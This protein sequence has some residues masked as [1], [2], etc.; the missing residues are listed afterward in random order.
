MKEGNPMP[1][2]KPFLTY[3][4]QL[5]KLTNEKNLVIANRKY[6]EQMLKQVGYFSLVSGYKE[7]F[8]NPTT[9]KYKD[10]T[11]FEEIVALY[12]FDEGLRE[13]FLRSLLAIE[14]KMRSLLSYYFTEHYGAEQVHYLSQAN[15]NSLPKYANEIKRLLDTLRDIAVHS[16]DNN[17]IVYQRKKHGNVPLWVLVKVLSFGNISHMYRV[18]P[19]SLQVRISKNF[20][21]VNEKELMQ[22]LRVLTKFRNV[23]AHNDRLFLYKTRDGIPDTNLHVK[24]EISKKG[25]EYVSGK[26]DL[27]CVVIALRYLLD[28]DDFKQF[29]GKLGRIISQFSLS[30]THITESDLLNKMGFPMNWK[31]IATF[32]I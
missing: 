7:L 11:T 5:N 23:C 24:L 17:Y 31:K 21:R 1:T 4:Q 19:Q 22:Y 8:R 16:N 15:Y 12:R 30:T 10:G 2:S 25:S 14:Q 9:N 6:A 18:L 32:Q 20:D 27:F 29:K 28:K 26:K 13:L 3:E